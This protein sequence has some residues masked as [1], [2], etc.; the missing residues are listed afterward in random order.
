MSK[1]SAD[2]DN[3]YEDGRDIATFTHPEDATRICAL[4]NEREQLANQRDQLRDALL[5]LLAN[6]DELEPCLVAVIP[7][8]VIDEV[9][10]ALA[11]SEP[12]TPNYVKHVNG[13]VELS[14]TLATGQSMKLP[15][16]VRPAQDT[17]H[18]TTIQPCPCSTCKAMREA[19]PS[20]PVKEP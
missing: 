13:I 1:F 6:L 20:T 12:S 8:K 17:H 11:A 16:H 7:T 15:E 19:E 9:R 3:L 5:V 4:L 2:I 18:L 14:G 10:A